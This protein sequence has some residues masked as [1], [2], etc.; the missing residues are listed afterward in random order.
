[1]TVTSVLAELPDPDRRRPSPRRLEA[2]L[3]RR[4][5]VTARIERAALDLLAEHGY[6]DVTV[7]GIAAA[8]GVSPRTFFRHFACKDDVVLHLQRQG[9]RR[10]CTAVARRPPGE[11]AVTALRAAIVAVTAFSGEERQMVLLHARVL[12]AIPALQAQAMGEQC[13]AAGPLVG[14]LA[15]R[16]GVDPAHDGRPALLAASVVAAAGV[17]FTRWVASGGEGDPSAA[18]GQAVDS[19]VRGVGAFSGG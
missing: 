16:M 7:E 17:A 11:D 1:V 18:I 6:H 2:T 9:L 12:A 14:A 19:V 15:E 5:A 3:H 4:W 13:S 8:A 10:L